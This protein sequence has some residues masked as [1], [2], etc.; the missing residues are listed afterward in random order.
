MTMT[1]RK[2]L[3][4]VPV[5]LVLL[6]LWLVASGLFA[7]VR[8]FKQEE[9]AVVLNAQRFSQSVSIPSVKDDLKKIVEVIGERNTG[10]PAQLSAM[11]SM[12]QGLLGL[13]NIGYDVKSMA[14]PGGFP[15]L[16]IT[17]PSLQS[18]AAPLWVIT[19]YDSPTGSR[20]AE[21]NA[22][23]V[24]ATLATAQALAATRPGRPVH[25]LFLP[26]ANDSAA[27]L[28]ETAQFAARLIQGALAPRA[29]LCIEAMGTAETLIL[30]SRDTEALPTA[31]FDGLGTIPGA[32]VVCLADD[33]DLSS[34]LF[35]MNL[36][37]LR[38]ATRPTLLPGE[39]DDKLP[40][41]PT[42]AASTGRLIEFIT[43]LLK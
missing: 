24:V 35:Q 15:V 6:P 25:F 13:S 36:P 21:K 16:Q 38:V 4:L 27:P 9:E 29:I 41:A 32:E 37:A 34:T 40:F 11:S 42:L 19:S 33:F 39:M 20:G 30:S 3:R 7:L 1:Q 8:Y 12:I 26:H 31:E 14:G 5:L 43:R 17:L 18:S 23:G 10:T 2:T 28:L 22:T